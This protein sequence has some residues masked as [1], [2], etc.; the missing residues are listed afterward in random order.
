MNA[1]LMILENKLK[2]KIIPTIK[3]KRLNFVC[4]PKFLKRNKNKFGHDSIV[5]YYK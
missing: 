4:I 3:M 2:L 5:K 1:C